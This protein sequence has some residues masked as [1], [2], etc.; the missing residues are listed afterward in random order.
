MRKIIKKGND[1]LFKIQNI[2]FKIYHAVISMK[3]FLKTL[4]VLAKSCCFFIF[5][6]LFYG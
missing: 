2:T 3:C 1:L 6:L 5:P 4:N